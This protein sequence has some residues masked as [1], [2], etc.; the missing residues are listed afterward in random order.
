[1]IFLQKTYLRHPYP[2]D[3]LSETQL[4]FLADKLPHP[5]AWTGRPAY[6]NLELL[7][8]ILKVLRSGCRWR[9]LNLPDYP[10]GTTHWRRLQFWKKQGYEFR[11]IWK[12]LLRMLRDNK[13]LQFTTVSIDG[14][15]IQSFAFKEKTGYSGKHHKTGTKIS[16]ISEETGIP[17]AMIVAKG[18]YVDIT[19]ANATVA[20][21]RIA[22]G[23]LQGGKLNGDKGYDCLDFRRYAA[24]WGLIPNI[25]K[26]DC[27]K[28]DADDTLWFYLYNRLE[29]KKRYVIERTNA[30]IKS[31]RRLRH[32]F[33]YKADSFE[34]FLYL[35]ILVICI[36]RLMP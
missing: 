34:A 9:D 23:S 24:E 21:I 2:T 20:S 6:S 33:D 10:D 7:P 14:S 17:L 28:G 15:L 26:R 22:K 27:T 35:A 25:P 16:T 29:G 1:V 8:G 30:W 13:Q 36:R 19:L 11:N 12:M 5:S 32:R 31:F 4:A 18:N 3:V